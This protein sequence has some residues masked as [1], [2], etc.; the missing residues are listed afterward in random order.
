MQSST[1]P[2][3][4]SDFFLF[5]GTGKRIEREEEEEEEAL[6]LDMLDDDDR[7]DRNKPRDSEHILKVKPIE[8]ADT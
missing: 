7:R 3:L 6:P 4:V 2:I 5:C 1:S 8:F